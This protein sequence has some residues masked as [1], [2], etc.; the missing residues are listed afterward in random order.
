M[1]Y[2]NLCKFHLEGIKKIHSITPNFQEQI[3][4]IIVN[5]KSIKEFED[6]H[7]Y[8]YLVD[9]KLTPEQDINL[10]N[11]I[12]CPRG[13]TCLIL[14]LLSERFDFVD[15]FMQ[16]FYINYQA[17]SQSPYY[18]ALRAAIIIQNIRYFTTLLKKTFPNPNTNNINENEVKSYFNS[19]LATKNPSILIIFLEYFQGLCID[20]AK[21]DD[22]DEP[23]SNSPMMDSITTQS[24]DFI[25]ILKYHKIFSKN[26]G[27]LEFIEEQLSK[28]LDSS[29]LTYITE[30]KDILTDKVDINEKYQQITE[31]YYDKI[32]SAD[33]DSLCRYKNCLQK[34][35]IED[36]ETG[37]L[38][39]D[40]CYA[41]VL[42]NRY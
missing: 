7:V 25:I 26:D 11:N 33:N 9:S 5:G 38:Y 30:V 21:H 37:Y 31:K 32:H 35:T 8:E 20:F 24:K 3:V 28:T 16:H 10:K 18:T 41:K 42:R 22:E 19:I 12:Y 27:S 14:S 39:C 23:E 6:L 29:Y 40:R 2:W 15:Y 34:A 36:Q 13:P 17:T 4:D 1:L